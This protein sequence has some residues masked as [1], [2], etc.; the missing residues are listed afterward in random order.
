MR[1]VND[2][3][4]RE[5]S[6]VIGADSVPLT[7]T[8]SD[9]DSRRR[10]RSK[11]APY[12]IAIISRPMRAGLATVSCMA[13][14]DPGR[15]P[16]RAMLTTSGEPGSGCAVWSCFRAM[17]AILRAHHHPP[18]PLVVVLPLCLVVY[19]GRRAQLMAATVDRAQGGVE[20]FLEL[21]ELAVDVDVA[22]AG[23]PITLSV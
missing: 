3:R 19:A 16:N 5:H 18:P 21:G 15:R 10:S 6:P 22:F 14:I 12:A 2:A 20:V 1:S 9:T 17:S 23:Q 8:P 7:R 13:N 11:G 4:Q